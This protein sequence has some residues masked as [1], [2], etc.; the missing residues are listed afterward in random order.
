MGGYQMGGR[1]CQLVKLDH[2]ENKGAT[3]R[4]TTHEVMIYGKYDM[5]M[6]V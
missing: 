5:C 3:F 1:H 4:M 2:G 6:S